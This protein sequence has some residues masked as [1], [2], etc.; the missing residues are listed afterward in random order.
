MAFTSRK[1]NTLIVLFKNDMFLKYLS[2]KRFKASWNFRNITK[3][4]CLWFKNSWLEKPYNCSAGFIEIFMICMIFALHLQCI[5]YYYM[6]SL[7]SNWASATRSHSESKYF[8]L[9]EVLPEKLTHIIVY[10]RFDKPV[11]KTQSSALVWL[12][13]SVILTQLSW[14]AP[15]T[16]SFD[17]RW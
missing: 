15:F 9:V 17:V 8:R 14:D 7:S 12:Y 3:V 16:L 11:T 10:T 5:S 2:R 1:K 13:L 4:Q 6:T